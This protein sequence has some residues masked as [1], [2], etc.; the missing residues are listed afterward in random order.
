MRGR[1]GTARGQHGCGA[2]MVEH[3][4]RAR[5]VRRELE[6]KVGVGVTYTYN[7]RVIRVILGRSSVERAQIRL[8]FEIVCYHNFNSL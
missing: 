2:V 1:D 3:D 7:I 4:G 8:M 5:V 6:M